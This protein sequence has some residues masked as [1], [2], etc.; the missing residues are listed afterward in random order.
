MRMAFYDV[1]SPARGGEKNYMSA[2]LTPLFGQI[3]NALVKMDAPMLAGRA[4]WLPSPQAPSK[5]QGAA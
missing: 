2:L 1:L 4:R 5:S 3:A